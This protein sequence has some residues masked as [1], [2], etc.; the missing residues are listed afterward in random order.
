MIEELQKKFVRVAMLAVSILI[1]GMLG[2]VNLLNYMSTQKQISRELEHTIEMQRPPREEPFFQRR[3]RENEFV[4]FS[5]YVVVYYDNNGQVSNVDLSK[6]MFIEQEDACSLTQKIY[7]MKKV[8]GTIEN[9]CYKKFEQKDG[10]CFAIVLMDISLYRSSNLRIM[11]LS[12]VIGV[13]CWGIMLLFVKLLSKR[14]IQ[15]IAKNIEK[16]R[17][18]V[19][20][21][22]HEIKTP[23]AIMQAN[24]D[25]LELNLGENKWT[26][27]IKN[28]I[29]RLNGLMQNLLILS[30]MDEGQM[31]FEKSELQVGDIVAAE[32][33]E[34]Q[35]AAMLRKIVVEKNIQ[36]DI[37]WNSNKEAL[38]QLVT[39]LMDNAIK[40][41]NDNGNIKVVLKKDQ[42]LKLIVENTCKEV[43]KV[44]PNQLFERFFRAD[45][46]RNQKDGG[47]GIGLSIAYAIV[48]AMEGKIK[49]EYLENRV[50]FIVEL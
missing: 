5:Q 3:E 45:A 30:K 23:L 46:A 32:V 28:Q 42:S 27:N 38:H 29:S 7:E 35:E 39:I 9:Y 6:A 49:A 24:A 48:T 21:A 50:R 41:T 44:E 20:N 37:R 31:R 40:Y 26:G 12:I 33:E 17:Q 18:F 16:Q 15:P 14:A 2:T 1:L 4:R 36:E 8:Q 11:V 25:A 47:Y 43:P 13:L 19:T 10:S 22:G 34:Y